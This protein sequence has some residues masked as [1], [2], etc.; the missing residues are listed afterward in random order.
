MKGRGVPKFADLRPDEEI[1]LFD[2]VRAVVQYPE[3]PVVVADE[4]AKMIDELPDLP[5]GESYPAAWYDVVAPPFK[6]FFVEA[7]THIKA[8]TYNQPGVGPTQLPDTLVVRG[9]VVYNL[10]D[11]DMEDAVIAPKFRRHIPADTRW[12]LGMWCYLWSSDFRKL[13]MF[14]GALYVHLNKEG[15]ILDDTRKMQV[16]S[17]DNR[18][19]VDIVMLPPDVPKTVKTW[20]GRVFPPE[21][22]ANFVPFVLKAVSAMHKRCAVDEVTPGREARRRA[23]R[24]EKVFLHKHYV[25]KVKPTPVARSEDFARVGTPSEVGVREHKVRGHFRYYGESGLFGKYKNMM[26]WVPEHERGTDSYGMI[27]KDYRV[28]G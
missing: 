12:T 23:E 5:H 2:R 15:R 16:D 19:P 4:I 26:V 9:A 17:F 28:D 20:N 7:M 8:G 25:L 3:M 6:R 11:L 24:R 27:D 10:T 1:R 14:P 22:M 18:G 13:A 21:G